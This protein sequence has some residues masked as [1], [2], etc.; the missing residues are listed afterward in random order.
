M[1]ITTLRR[2]EFSASRQFANGRLHGNNYY[3]WAGVT[4]AVDQHTGM[5]INIVTLKKLL[6]ETLDG[7]D[8]RNLNAQMR[9]LE[10][11]TLNLTWTLWDDLGSRLP[12][13]ISMQSMEVMEMD[14]D[15]AY[16]DLQG[17]IK[18]VRGGFSAAH[19][20]HA[21]HLSQAENERLYGV[22]NNLAGHGHNY[23]VEIGLPRD[24]DIDPGL[25]KTFDHRNLSSDLPELVGRNVVTEAI[26][27]L[28]VSL[29]PQ[30]R[31][32]RVWETPDFYAEYI[33]NEK[34]YTLGR[35]YRFHAAHRLD[36]PHLTVE[37]NRRIYGKCNRPDPHGHTYSALVTVKGRLDP[38]TETAYD[39]GCLDEVAEGILG[40]LDYTYLDA[41]VPFFAELPTTGENIAAY[42]FARFSERL[43]HSL[44]K[45]QLWE[46][47]NNQFVAT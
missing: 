29:T 20:T 24:R 43:A 32:A 9:D 8:H 19:R 6:N 13:D 12:P 45:I 21:P 11:T 39:L 2:F 22:C 25:W 14:E 7:F 16:V 36:S 26:A 15:G 42:L 28:V 34:Q 3:G 27:E 44:E 1:K 4:G 18:V 47:P 46:T 35:R 38:L 40:E 30:A 23:Q 31:W 17:G 5:L 37:Q 41:E 10:P 33:P